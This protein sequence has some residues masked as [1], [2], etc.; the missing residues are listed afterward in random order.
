[1][2]LDHIGIYVKDLEKSKQFYET[3]LGFKQVNQFTSGAAKIIIMDIGGGL[4]E[5]VQ[6][7]NSPGIPP[8][9]DWSHI[10]F[11]DPNFDETVDKLDLLNIEKRLVTMANGNR[12]CFFNDPDGHTIEVMEHGLQSS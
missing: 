12:L 7:P 9:G 1:M 5:L 2:Q 4:L 11:F 6:R 3:I 8:I 10:A